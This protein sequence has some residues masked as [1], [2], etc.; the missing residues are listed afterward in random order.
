[1]GALAYLDLRY[2]RNQ[3]GTILR[4]PGRLALWLPY[5]GV[6]GY[7]A[8]SRAASAGNAQHSFSYGQLSHPMATAIGGAFLAMLGL[9]LLR[10][11]AGRITSFRSPAEAV[12]FVNAG[13]SPR[14]L[15]VWLQFRRFVS[16]GPRW[17]SAL[18]IWI[19]AFA[20]G[21]AGLGELG[22]LLLAS[23][24][25]AA[26]LTLLELPMFL[27]QRRG[28]GWLIGAAGW[29]A[30]ALGFVYTIAGVAT[31]LGDAG[32][33]PAVLGALHVDPGAA[34]FALV[35]G[36]PSVTLAFAAVPFLLVA[37]C[38]PLARD[39]IPELYQATLER[40]ALRERLGR[41]DPKHALRGAHYGAR[42]P[43]GALT[44]LWKDWVALRR[45][46][47][48]VWQVLFFSTFWT[49]LGGAIALTAESDPSLTYALLGFC[50]VYVVF[51]P[52]AVSSG[53]AA[54]ISN[55]LWWLSASSL[56]ARLAVWTFART[57]RGALA[58]AGLPLTLGYMAHN[59]GLM[60]AALP[61]ASAVWWSLHGL[62]LLFYAAF[63]N[64]A[65]MRGPVAFLRILVVLP[66]LTP[67]AVLAI[68][69]ALLTRSAAAAIAAALA[70]LVLQGALALEFA[71][72][73]IEANGAALAT[74]ERS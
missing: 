6:L 4:S 19:V 43:A 49:A 40:L 48:G 46:R 23:L 11:G 39:A 25:A 71:R 52:I 9:G 47:Y 62:G 41:G 24:I 15:V 53:L 55:P 2:L 73:R 3:I 38:P 35:D 32:I 44:L 70:L 64:R 22:R 17:I 60:L 21:S 31:M 33:A 68:A 67:P 14:A 59:V 7:F 57:W 51:V 69:V 42:I 13:I 29:S 58:L 28:A 63:P 30:V 72:H 18:V 36:P 10:S 8:Y 66:Y 45:R 34:A 27:A 12:L 26:S 74:L 1:M 20:P 56:R 65:D 37:L 54:E 50:G 16:A 61:A 5:L